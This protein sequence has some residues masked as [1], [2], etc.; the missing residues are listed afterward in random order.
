MA[1]ILIIEDDE[2]IVTNLSQL[3]RSVGHSVISARSATRARELLESDRDFALIILDHHLDRESGLEFLT[4]LRH[5][6]RHRTLPV[7]VCSG[8]TKPASVKSF[9]SLQIAGFI[10][11]PY[12]ADRMLSEI[13]RVLLVRDERASARSEADKTQPLDLH[14]TVP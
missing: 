11:K 14:R 7:I 12:L 2:K 13:K 5:S 8:D 3:L 6:G 9:L 4:A 1:N 10:V